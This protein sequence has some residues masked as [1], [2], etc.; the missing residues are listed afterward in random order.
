[1]SQLK[2]IVDTI[3]RSVLV[4]G[5]GIFLDKD[6]KSLSDH[7]NKYSQKN[8]DLVYYYFDHDNLI[9]PHNAITL[10]KIQKN[11][12]DFYK[13][14]FS[15]N[16][17]ELYQ[18]ISRIPF[19]LIIS[20]NPDTTMMDCYS[21]LGL[22]PEFD[23]YIKG[24]KSYINELPE[25]DKPYLFNLLGC[26]TEHQSLILTP[27]DL[28]EYLRNILP[29]DS[30]PTSI[31]T[32]LRNAENIVFLGVEFDKWYFQLL[33]KL[34][35]EFDEKFVLLRYAAPDI[36]SDTSIKIVC[37][38]NFKITFVGPDVRSYINELYYYFSESPE[39]KLR[40]DLILTGG[41]V[42]NPEIYLS[43][44]HGSDSEIIAEKVVKKGIE[45]GYNIIYDKANLEYRGKTWEFM[46][47]IGLG[48][49]VIVIMSDAYMKSEYCMFE[50]MEI[51]KKGENFEEKVFPVVIEDA[52]IYKVSDWSKYEEYWEG[53]IEKL[54]VDLHKLDSERL[55]VSIESIKRYEDVRDSIPK[56]MEFFGKTKS[57]TYEDLEVKG[58]A[59]LFDMIQNQI[60]DDL[61]N[62]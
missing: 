38:K 37:E 50:F 19:P 54:K 53:E 13:N 28:F 16:A 44:K 47:R 57:W 48:K 25:I 59:S 26:Y 58:C 1:M 46:K 27:D 45:D 52:D 2:N 21:E 41:K 32:T 10:G 5:P 4:I 33:V 18:K 8:T 6:G 61:R 43:Y 49:Y 51:M 3:E 20:L 55:Y 60:D 17:K 22:K 23:F 39:K 7:Y 34:L 11:F 56:M 62:G 30:L 15:K 42:F 14:E 35:T 12:A 40:G 31:R 36:S 24:K 9:R 29:G